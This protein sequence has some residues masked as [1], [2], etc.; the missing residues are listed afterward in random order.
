MSPRLNSRDLIIDAAEAI[1][2][3][4]GAAHLTLDAV[5]AKAQISKGGLMYH[6]PNK[7]HLLRA[8]VARLI[9]RFNQMRSKAQARVGDKPA[10]MLKAHVTTTLSQ[11]RVSRLA[12]AILAAAANEP[13][14]LKPMRDYYSKRFEQ[15]EEAGLRIEDVAVVMLATTGLSMFEQLRISPFNG[16]Q[17]RRIIEKL[18]SLIEKSL[19][20]K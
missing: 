16:K 18:M 4:V 17:R 11:P 12:A 10:A 6:F 1:V 5:A 7:D 19:I 2:A 13:K 3:E 14:L 9:D 8:M 15:F 20:K